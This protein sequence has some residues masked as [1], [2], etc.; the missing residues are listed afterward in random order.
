[1]PLLHLAF[2]LLLKGYIWFYVYMRLSY[3][4][5][6]MRQDESTSY[7]YAAFD[8]LHVLFVAILCKLS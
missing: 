5:V 2:M 4:I 6:L 1:M 8:L 7:C 3:R